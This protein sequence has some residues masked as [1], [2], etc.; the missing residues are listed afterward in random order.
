MHTTDCAYILRERWES[1]TGAFRQRALEAT[2]PRFQLNLEKSLGRHDNRFNGG[3]HPDS[4]TGPPLPL[5]THNSKYALHRNKST[6]P[7]LLRVDFKN[8]S[9]KFIFHPHIQCAKLPLFFY[10]SSADSRFAFTHKDQ[11]AFHS[12]REFDSIL[13]LENL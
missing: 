8:Q 10:Q 2:N 7:T 11:N 6:N 5:K 3:H 1:L 4:N 12:S 13:T 9:S